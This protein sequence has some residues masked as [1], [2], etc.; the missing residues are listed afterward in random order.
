MR[1]E[2]LGVWALASGVLAL[3][4]CG[5]ALLFL[6]FG[7]SMASFA[8]LDLLAPYQPLFQSVSIILL[9][10]AWGRLYRRRACMRNSRRTFWALLGIT[11]L[12]VGLL[13][14]PYIEFA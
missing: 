2:T 11:A 8:F 1:T 13:A 4:C 3:S 7:V 14:V 6:L 10:L 9:V 5:S 12:L